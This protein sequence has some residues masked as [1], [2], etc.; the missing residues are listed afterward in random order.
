[1]LVRKFTQ[2]QMLEIFALHQQESITGCSC[3]AMQMN[4]DLVAQPYSPTWSEVKTLILLVCKERYRLMGSLIPIELSY[5]PCNLGNNHKHNAWL[6]IGP[7]GIYISFQSTAGTQ[8]I[9]NHYFL[10]NNDHGLNNVQSTHG[11]L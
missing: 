9:S 7:F 4:L 1:M 8:H 10:S 3:C 2:N 5:K 11:K 6:D